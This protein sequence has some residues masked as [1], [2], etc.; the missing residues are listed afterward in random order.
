MKD[1]VIKD[2]SRDELEEVLKDYAVRFMANKY[3]IDYHHNSISVIK[4]LFLSDNQLKVDVT[5]GITS[6]GYLKRVNKFKPDFEIVFK[7]KD[8][9]LEELNW[10]LYHQL[11]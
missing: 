3:G 7:T 10:I 1:K 11:L 8:T 9:F 2:L 6:D 4:K 5:Y